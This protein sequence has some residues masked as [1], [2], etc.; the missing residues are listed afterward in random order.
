MNQNDIQMFMKRKKW[1][2]RLWGFDVQQSVCY[3]VYARLHSEKKRTC[4]H[5][6]IRIHTTNTFAH[7]AYWEGKVEKHTDKQAVT[8]KLYIHF[9]FYLR[10]ENWHY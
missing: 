2:V 6:P 1:G 7:S 8:Y 4:A 5:P 9:A 10:N 3:A